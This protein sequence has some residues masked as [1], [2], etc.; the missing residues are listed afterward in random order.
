MNPTSN[1]SETTKLPSVTV[2]FLRQLINRLSSS[3]VSQL[4][5]TFEQNINDNTETLSIGKSVPDIPVAH[6]RIIHPFSLLLACHKGI[7][8]WT[9]AYVHGHWETSH[10]KDT[11][12]WALANEAVLK[13]TFSTNRISHICRRII[14]FLNRN[15][16]KGSKRNIAAHYDL[17]NDF[18]R[19]WLDRTMTYSSALF[20]HAHETLEEGQQ[21][22]YQKISSWLDLEHDHKLLEIGCGWGGFARHIQ[23]KNHIQYAGITLSKEQLRYVKEHHS[24]PSST[25]P[26][27][28]CHFYLKDY[29]DIK[30][31]Y[32]R[33]VSI[34]M[35]EAVGEKWWPTYFNKVAD[36]LKPGG[37]AVIQAITIDD[38]RFESYRK[39][40]DFI[41]RYIFPGGMLA[42]DKIIKQRANSAQLTVTQSF[43]FGKSYARTLQFWSEEFKNHWDKIKSYGFDSQFKRLWHFYLAYCESGFDQ[44]LIDVRLYQLKKKQ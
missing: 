23:S 42:S 34:E 11:L 39:E 9:E 33:I 37:I 18:Y 12:H 26:S 43:N 29:R 24:H 20:Y 28:S 3:A 14:H 21:N 15:S 8:G 31:T 25:T 4:D 38:S 30:D 36:S 41:Q 16:K 6:I 17:G 7:T 35:I 32:D 10:L 40:A 44:E 5:I 13:Q 22:K 19:Q 27:D 1:F 2:F